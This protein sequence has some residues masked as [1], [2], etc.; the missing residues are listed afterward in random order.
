MVKCFHPT[1]YLNSH[2]FTSATSNFRT[3][4]ASTKLLISAEYSDVICKSFAQF[5]WSQFDL[6]WGKHQSKE[7]LLL[8][9]LFTTFWPFS[10]RIAS[11]VWGSS[12][13]IRISYLSRMWL[14]VAGHRACHN[15]SGLIFRLQPIN[16]CSNVHM[17]INVTKQDGGH[18][19]PV[20]E[21][22]NW[23]YQDCR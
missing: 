15:L 4:M 8:Y 11:V 10:W 12:S 23:L 1:I 19:L 6:F 18:K 21:I 16:N 5:E 17:Q 14:F 2:F 9:R 3:L 20:E 22:S 7:T 13:S